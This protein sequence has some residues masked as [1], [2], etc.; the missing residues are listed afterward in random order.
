M[1]VSMG[2]Y[3]F[4]LPAFQRLVDYI[5]LGGYPRWKGDLRPDYVVAMKKAVEQSRQWLF[6]GLTF[7]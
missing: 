4:S 3:F 6:N 7:S 1:S 5:W 2:E